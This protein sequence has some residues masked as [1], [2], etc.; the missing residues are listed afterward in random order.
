MKL[1]KL[2]EAVVA[3]IP[4]SSVPESEVSPARMAIINNKLKDQPF[5]KIIDASPERVWVEF[6][7]HGANLYFYFD[8]DT[9]V[10][11]Q[12]D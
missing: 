1:V 4:K 6:G 2:L 7:Q 3:G 5:V 9:L 10:D 11:L 12:G 8:G